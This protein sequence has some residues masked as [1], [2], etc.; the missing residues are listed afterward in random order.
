MYDVQKKKNMLGDKAPSCLFLYSY[1]GNGSVS[2]RSSQ[3]Q[4]AKPT[5]PAVGAQ[6]GWGS[7]VQEQVRK[8]C[9]LVYLV[10]GFPFVF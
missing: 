3:N 10:N 8:Q 4:D 9:S 1:G 6:Y 5:N 2:N 7:Y